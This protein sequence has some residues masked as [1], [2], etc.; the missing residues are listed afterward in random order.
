MR[1]SRKKGFSF[2]AILVGILFAA[3]LLSDLPSKHARSISEI[4]LLLILIGAFAWI[5]REER[6]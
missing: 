5:I 6:A 4:S 1:I 3:Y 2:V